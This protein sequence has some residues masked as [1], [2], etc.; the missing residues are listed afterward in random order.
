MKH[1][2]GEIPLLELTPLSVGGHLLDVSARAFE[3]WRDLAD[4]KGYTLTITSVGDAY[5]TYARQRAVF[6]ARYVRQAT[7]IGRYGDVRWWNGIRYV[8]ATGAAAAVP[9]TSNHGEATTV[10]IRNAGPFGGAFHDWMLRTGP[11]LGWS[12]DEGRGVNEPW[13]WVHDGVE[14]V[15]Y[16]SS[17]P[18]GLTPSRPVTLYPI[19]TQEGPL[20][21]LSHDEQY[22]MLRR[23]RNLDSQTTGADNQTPS[24]ASRV[25]AIEEHLDA[26]PRLVWESRVTGEDPATGVPQTHSAASWVTVAAF[27][28]AAGQSPAAVVEAIPSEI[29]REVLE[30]LGEKL[31]RKS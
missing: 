31:G 13:H 7:G 27:R 17:L 22:E 18:T 11:L 1:P 12:N 21:A 25:I 24:I 8:R 26:L 28:I 10:D 3:T 5:R 29:A 20:M 6:V 9:G 23:V 30:L 19:I 14:R 15:S 2:N 16:L 4:D